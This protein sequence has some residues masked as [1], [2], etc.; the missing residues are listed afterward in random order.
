MFE[1]VDLVPWNEVRHCYG[2]A[3]NAPRQ[4]RGLDS[5]DP[6]ERADAV[7]EFLWSSAF[8]QWTLYPATPF[9]I[10]FIVEALQS[11]PLV[12][13]DNGCGGCSMKRELLHFVRLCAQAGQRAIAGTPHPQ[14]L[15]IEEAVRAGAAVYAMYVK[16]ETPGVAEDAAW[17][18]TWCARG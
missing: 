11:R 17:L 13:R 10:P 18:V 8:H 1:G 4:I 5:E 6:D 14:A 12:E 9:V 3:S 2:P 15:T 16:D 7:N